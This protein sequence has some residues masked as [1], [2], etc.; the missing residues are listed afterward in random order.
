MDAALVFYGIPMATWEAHRRHIVG[1]HNPGTSFGLWGLGCIVS[2]FF[3]TLLA[4]EPPLCPNPAARL[5]SDGFYIS[6]LHVNAPPSSL[7]LAA[8]LHAGSPSSRPAGY[9]FGQHWSTDR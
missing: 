2:G 3:F 9:H 6:G 4:R 7:D 8:H 1:I 5:R